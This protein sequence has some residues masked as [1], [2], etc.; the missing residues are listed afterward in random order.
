MHVSFLSKVSISGVVAHPYK[1][2]FKFK[3]FLNKKLFEIIQLSL[4]I[5]GL[6]ETWQTL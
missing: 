5:M 6:R 2:K 1:L 4:Q 3:F